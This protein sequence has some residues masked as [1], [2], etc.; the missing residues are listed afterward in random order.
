MIPERKKH[1]SSKVNLTISVVVHSVLIVGLIFFAAR[2]GMLGKKLKQITVTMVPKEK[3]PEPP[4][5]KAPEPKVEAAKV[6]EAP[7]TLAVAAPP[8]VESAAPPPSEASPTVAP[9]AV[10]LSAFE[11]SD[12]A[13]AVETGDANSVYKGLI[14]HALRSRWERPEGIADD[15]FVAEV[16]LTVDPAGQASSYRWLRGSGNAT[17]DDSVRVAM[18]KTKVFSRPPPKGFPAKFTVRFDVESLRTEDV[19][20][21]SSR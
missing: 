9:A 15:A 8:R 14:E 2:E 13:H 20:E 4:K 16:E 21:I 5:E 1:N 17:W 19:I 10:N 7:K 6:T 11:F 3:K 12:G 18:N